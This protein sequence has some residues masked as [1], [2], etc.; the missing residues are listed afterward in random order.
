M[1]KPSGFVKEEDLEKLSNATVMQHKEVAAK[2]SLANENC[3][4]EKRVVRAPLEIV[5]I[6]DETWDYYR[7]RQLLS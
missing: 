6:L 1:G 5:T 2:I 7:M 4:Y 3:E